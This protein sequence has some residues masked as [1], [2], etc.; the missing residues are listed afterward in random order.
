[1]KKLTEKDF[2]FVCPM[3]WDEM[4]KSANGRFCAGC[5]KEV[6]DLSSCSVGEVREL[7]RKH[8]S[9]CGSIKVVRAAA[10]AASLTAAA[11][12]DGGMTR[13]TGTPL[14]PPKD[15]SENPNR[16]LG[17]IAAPPEEKPAQQPMVLGKICLPEESKKKSGE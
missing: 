6:F 11:C 17:E 4:P 1:M 10:V 2:S 8:G 7:Q 15:Q 16:T 13:T 5:R 14:P 12:Q 9:I 3:V